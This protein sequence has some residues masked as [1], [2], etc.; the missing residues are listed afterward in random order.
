MSHD[1]G[2]PVEKAR[3]TEGRPRM[4]TEV[5]PQPSAA[6]DVDQAD[7]KMTMAEALLDR[8]IDVLDQQ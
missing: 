4:L 7:R 5:T 1:S 2:S 8:A 3:D 6:H